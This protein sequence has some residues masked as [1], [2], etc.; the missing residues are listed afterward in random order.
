MPVWPITPIDSRPSVTLTE[1]AVFE[2]PHLGPDKPWT[3]HLAGWSCEDRQG[4]VSS[5]VQAFDPA[6]G[7]CITRSGRV[8]QLRGRPGLCGDG[9]YVWGVWMERDGLKEARDVTAEVQLAI[10][11]ARVAAGGAQ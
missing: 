4:Q 10:Q 8:Y 7:K 1:W 5:A 6:T 9:R 2:V 11:K 3:R